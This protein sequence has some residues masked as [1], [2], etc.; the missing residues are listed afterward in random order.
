MQY[1]RRRVTYEMALSSG[2]PDEKNETKKSLL[3]EKETYPH[4]MGGKNKWL[5]K[6]LLPGSTRV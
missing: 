4:A 3:D 6:T 5:V 1:G 2:K